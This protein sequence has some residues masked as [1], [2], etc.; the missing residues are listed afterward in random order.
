MTDETA[1]WKKL[2]GAGFL[3]V[4]HDVTPFFATEIERVLD[5]LVPLV[6]TRLSAAVVP[7]WHGGTSEDSHHGFWQTVS[8]SFQEVLLHGDHH[9]NEKSATWLSLLTGSADEFSRLTEVECDARIASG[10][11]QM[12]C[13]IQNRPVGFLPPAWQ[14]GR[15]TPAVL[16]RH[17]LRFVLGMHGLEFVGHGIIPL[18]TWSWDWGRIG[19]LGHVAETYG[20]LRSRWQP[21]ALPTIAIHPADVSRGF[22]PRAV[23]ICQRLLEEGRRPVL[24]VELEQRLFG[25]A[26]R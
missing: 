21:W 17:G 9:L 18:T 8:D 24:A 26:A 7:C 1:R 2:A 6:G 3:V 4:V 10:L 15:V 22:L 13:L 19:W 20:S 5:A 14:R 12:A 25:G 11:E 23:L 16:L